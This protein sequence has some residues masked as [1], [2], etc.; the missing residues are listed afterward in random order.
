MDQ[1]AG[2]L[3]PFEDPAAHLGL[4]FSDPTAERDRVDT[5]ERSHVRADVL[6]RAVTE[7]LDRQRGALVAGRDGFEQVAHVARAT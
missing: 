2:P 7:E 6:T 1:N 3:H 5:A 4:V